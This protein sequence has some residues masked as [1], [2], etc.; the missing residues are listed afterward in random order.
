MDVS[1]LTNDEIAAISP[2]NRLHGPMTEAE[3]R[4]FDKMDKIMRGEAEYD[5]T[6]ENAALEEERRRGTELL[7]KPQQEEKASDAD[8]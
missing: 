1:G 8:C 5:L 6:E 4:W 7:Q 3:R 2:V